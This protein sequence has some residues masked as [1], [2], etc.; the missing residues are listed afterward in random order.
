MRLELDPEGLK[1]IYIQITEWLENE[2]LSGRIKSDERIYSQYQLA[3]IFNINPA[4]AARGLKILADEGM[5]YKKRGLGMF[6]S[7][8]AVEKIRHKRINLTL[9]KMVEALVVEAR[10]LKVD[11]DEL[12][13]MI[14]KS[15][16]QGN[17]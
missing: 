13:D 14:R 7:P 12:F 17:P 8:G 6:L 11:Q 10:R 16:E 4:T 15:R 9:K 5:L 3:E 1:P 2:I